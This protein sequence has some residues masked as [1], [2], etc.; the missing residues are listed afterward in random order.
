MAELSSSARARALDALA[1]ASGRE[2]TAQS[3]ARSRF[4]SWSCK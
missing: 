4:A 3:S 2:L 1:Q